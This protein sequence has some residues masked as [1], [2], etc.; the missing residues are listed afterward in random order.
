MGQRLAL[1]QGIS[2]LYL[3]GKQPLLVGGV[4][5][6][7][8]ALFESCGVVLHLTKSPFGSEGITCSSGKSAERRRA[9]CSG[10]SLSSLHI[11]FC[12]GTLDTV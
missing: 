4:D 11:Q 6:C 10:A 2:C 5:P 12:R 3:V 7:I 8:P 1:Q 9:E